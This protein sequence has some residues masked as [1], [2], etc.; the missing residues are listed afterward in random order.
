MIWLGDPCGRAYANCGDC[1]SCSFTS[2][3]ILWVLTLSLQLCAA[4]CCVFLSFCHLPDRW[5]DLHRAAAK[6]QYSKI[7]TRSFVARNPRYWRLRTGHSLTEKDA[8]TSWFRSKVGGYFKRRAKEV[9]RWEDWS[10]FERALQQTTTN[11][12]LEATG[13]CPKQKNCW[14]QA[15]LSGVLTNERSWW[16]F[17]VKGGQFLDFQGILRRQRAAPSTAQESR[18]EDYSIYL[19]P[20]KF[21][22]C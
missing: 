12:L 21:W 7:C 16:F 1:D 4:W 20:Q 17:S 10:E 9:H 2:C 11:I 13:V 19:Q 8:L 15:L 22:K 18:E 14:N 3:N 5:W 6:S